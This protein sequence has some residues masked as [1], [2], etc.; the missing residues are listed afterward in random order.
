VNILEQE[1]KRKQDI[2]APNK[3]IKCLD[4]KKENKDINFQ[5]FLR[6]E[7]ITLTDKILAQKK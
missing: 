3:Y 4:W 7:R 5:K 6:S 2:P 1:A